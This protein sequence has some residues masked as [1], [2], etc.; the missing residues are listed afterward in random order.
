M[1][2]GTKGRLAIIAGLLVMAAG[3]YVWF[4]SSHS[5]ADATEQ[6]AAPRDAG[7]NLRLTLDPKLFQGEVREAYEVA[8]RD[9]ALLAQLHCY[10]GCDKSDGHKSLLDCYRDKHGSTC[11]IC[12][13]EAREAEVL[14]KQ[15]MPVEQIRDSLRN[16]FG[17]G[18]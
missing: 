6:T 16:R 18:D 7:T 2:T 10:C 12:V 17:H 3:A 13:G 15:G 1:L 9:P 8:E 4:G 11:A 5:S 14:A